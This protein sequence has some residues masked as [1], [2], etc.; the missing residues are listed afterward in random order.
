MSPRR[1]PGKV[2]SGWSK[3]NEW[4]LH[5]PLPAFI[6]VTV[7]AAWATG[8]A[9]QAGKDGQRAADKANTA[10][11]ASE[12]ERDARVRVGG[13]IYRYVCKEN[14]KQDR[15]LAGLIEV[16]LG[17]QSSFGKGIAPGELTVFDQAVVDAIQTVQKLSSEQQAA[18][19]ESAFVRALAQL[20]HPTPCRALIAAFTEASDTRDY[21]AIRAFF[22][23]LDRKEEEVADKAAPAP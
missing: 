17:G 4:L 9:W 12:R 20:R 3:A 1:I 16:S 15:I 7:V 21:K 14:N 23:A 11:Q 8:T 2:K 6:L 13:E 22:K 10:I 5:N 19:F 18:D